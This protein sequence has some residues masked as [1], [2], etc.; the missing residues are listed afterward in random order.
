MPPKA[1]KKVALP[2]MT[3][4]SSLTKE[5]FE[6]ELIA[7]KAKAQTETTSRHVMGQVA[8]IFAAFRVLSYAAAYSNIS[9]Y[10]LSPVYGAIPAGIWHSKVVMTAAFIGW[11]SNLWLKR[12]LP[13]GYKSPSYFIPAIAFYIPLIQL[14]LFRLSTLFGAIWGP[15]ITEALTFAPLMLLS[16]ANAAEILEDLDFG[17]R[18]PSYIG[19]A[20]PGMLSWGAFRTCEVLFNRYLQEIIGANVFVSRIGL[21]FVL[22]GCYAMMAPS[23]IIFFAVPGLFHTIF[24]NPH[25]QSPWATYDLNTQLQKQGYVI[26]DRQ[27]SLTGYM[28]VIEST[29]DQFRVMRCDHSLLGGE[30]LPSEGSPKTTVR[31]PIYGVF[32]MLE[33]VRLVEVK[34]SRSGGPENALVM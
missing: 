28:S 6:K 11:S 18:L 14:N 21:Q 1:A 3:G 8:V 7:L 9:Q 5:N 15:V 19:D 16:A 31:E 4:A 33:A 27:D 23:K 17:G 10:T 13:K 29:K 34:T 2:D 24:M 12:I 32:A 30:W 25:F 20:L 22:N 26:L